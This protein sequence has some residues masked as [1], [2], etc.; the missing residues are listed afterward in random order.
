MS[1]S[2]A[3]AQMTY[4]SHLPSR[5]GRAERTDPGGAAREVSTGGVERVR[6]TAKSSSQTRACV[7]RAGTSRARQNTQR[8][9]DLGE[10]RVGPRCPIRSTRCRTG[11]G[12]LVIK[13]ERFVGKSLGNLAASHGYGLYINAMFRS[14]DSLPYGPKTILEKGDVLR[15]TGSKRRIVELSQDSGASSARA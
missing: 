12:D 2:F 7:S 1:S 15:V 8:L 9:I 11:D 4:G 6:G 5:S 3:K 13:N 10:E 14:G